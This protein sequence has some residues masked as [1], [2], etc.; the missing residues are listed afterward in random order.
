MAGS[1]L[2][3]GGR[4]HKQRQRQAA[5]NQP[6]TRRRARQS[7]ATQ[8]RVAR[9][10]C[11]RWRH[12]TPVCTALH[13]PCARHRIPA[14]QPE[15]SRSRGDASFCPFHA[16]L[17]APRP[18]A[19]RY[20]P[21]RT[22]RTADRIVPYVPGYGLPVPVA[23]RALSSRPSLSVSHLSLGS[24]PGRGPFPFG[25]GGWVRRPGPARA[26]SHVLLLAG[27]A[28]PWRL[29]RGGGGTT[30]GN[31]EWLRLAGERW[32][33]WPAT[34]RSYRLLRSIGPVKH[35][36]DWVVDALHSWYMI[37]YRVRLRVWLRRLFFWFISQLVS[38]DAYHVDKGTG[39]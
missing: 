9:P 29:W 33:R 14:I 11:W 15:T 28:T 21:I 32:I 2:I 24:L 16:R 19:R 3:R 37:M 36:R 26:C 7:G 22:T 8:S 31:H 4:W 13:S 12:V 20:V 23:R 17:S 38:C 30:D 25:R 27:R 35:A 10:R 34:D 1:R 39:V 5:S 6:A 18:R